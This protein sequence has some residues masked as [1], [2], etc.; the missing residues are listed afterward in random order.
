MS[1]VLNVILAMLLH[2]ISQKKAHDELDAVLGP[3]RLPDFDDR[4]SLPYVDAIVM[5]TLRWHPVLPL[6]MIIPTISDSDN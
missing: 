6:S 2:P 3:G 1:F 5:E 4:V